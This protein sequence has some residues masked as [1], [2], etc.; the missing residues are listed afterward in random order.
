MGRARWGTYIALSPGGRR[1]AVVDSDGVRLIDLRTREE[2]VDRVGQWGPV[3]W[4]GP[5]Q[6]LARLGGGRI[7]IYDALLRAVK[8]YGPYRAFG[9][10]WLGRRLFG[11]NGPRVVALDIMTGAR[12]TVTELPDEDV[13]DLDALSARPLVGAARKQPQARCGT[14]SS[15]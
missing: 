13:Y 10:A 12:R 15:P 6:L 3:A 14:T 9:D 7:R 5:N 11:V 1:V 4:L 2:R 8:A